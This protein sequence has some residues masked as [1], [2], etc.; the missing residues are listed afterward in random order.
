VNTAIASDYRVMFAR[1][2]VLSARLLAAAVT[3]ETD[4]FLYELLDVVLNPD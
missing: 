3:D 4:W 1:R 2:R